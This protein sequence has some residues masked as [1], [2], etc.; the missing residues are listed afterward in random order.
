MSTKSPK[1]VALPNKAHN[2]S[3]FEMDEF[4]SSARGEYFK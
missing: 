2:Y 4:S 3:G 1:D